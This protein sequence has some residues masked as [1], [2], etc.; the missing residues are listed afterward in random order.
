MDKETYFLVLHCAREKQKEVIMNMQ[1]PDRAYYE[2]LINEYKRIK[3]KDLT[4]FVIMH[5][6]GKYEVFYVE[7]TVL[8]NVFK[9]T[10]GRIWFNDGSSVNHVW[11]LDEVLQSVVDTLKQD[12]HDVLIHEVYRL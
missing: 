10:M 11:I 1:F 6:R 4:K 5:S 7:A 9:Y 8:N 2:Q 12:R 3:S